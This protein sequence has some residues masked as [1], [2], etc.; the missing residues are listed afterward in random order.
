MRGKKEKDPYDV[1]NG[2]Q[3]GGLHQ[4]GSN[5]GATDLCQRK[6]WLIRKGPGECTSWGSVWA[7]GC[8][9]LPG[10]VN[11]GQKSDPG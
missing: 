2:F 1:Y 7:Q 4:E 9:G 10:E 3:G 11:I 8:Q 5:M 6:E